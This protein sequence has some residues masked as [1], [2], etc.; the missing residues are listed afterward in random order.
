MIN[1]GWKYYPRP[2]PKRKRSYS[3]SSCTMPSPHAHTY[4]HT[5]IHKLQQNRVKRNHQIKRKKIQTTDRLWS[6]NF[7][8]K[9]FE[10]DIQTN[11]KYQESFQLH[12]N[13]LNLIQGNELKLLLI[14]C[15]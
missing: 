1:F 2:T 13:K 11:K 12:L 14:F 4:I 5:Q 8:L 9:G 6:N 3:E 7:L 10:I 15:H